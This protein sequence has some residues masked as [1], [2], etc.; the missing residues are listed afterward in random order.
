M[1]FLFSLRVYQF[2]NCHTSSSHSAAQPCAVFFN[3]C[4]TV[5]VVRNHLSQYCPKLT[6][7]LGFPPAETGGYCG[8]AVQHCW[9]FHVQHHP[10]FLSGVHPEPEPFLEGRL[11]PDV[12][13]P[14]GQSQSLECS[15]F[16][17]YCS[18]FY[19]PL[20]LMG[21]LTFISHCFSCI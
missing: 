8:W 15:C 14:C 4:C 21:Q 17:F 1:H 19:S 20:G 7:C 6:S 10:S 13:W 18:L 11:W 5:N 16:V 3:I 12:S 9:L 2:P